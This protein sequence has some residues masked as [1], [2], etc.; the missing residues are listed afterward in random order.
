MGF[1]DRFRSNPTPAPD[2]NLSRS[3]GTYLR[4]ITEEE[5]DIL[6]HWYDIGRELY[7]F[8]DGATLGEMDAKFCAA[9]DAY[10]A[11]PKE[12]REDPTPWILGAAGIAGAAVASLSKEDLSWY[13]LSDEYG[14]D[15]VV[16]L[17][18]DS[19]QITACPRTAMEKR[20]MPDHP[21]GPA[22]WVQNSVEKLTS[23]ITSALNTWSNHDSQT[24][25]EILD[26][27]GTLDGTVER[28]IV[29][30]PT[31][32]LR[33]AAMGALTLGEP[34]YT[35]LI[36]SEPIYDSDGTPVFAM[37]LTPTNVTPHVEDSIV[38]NRNHIRQMIAPFEGQYGY[39]TL[40]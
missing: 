8:E 13:F 18:T 26:E 37:F 20:W 14:E 2:D 38:R 23:D 19:H 15:L 1:F 32:E 24:L 33:S 30:F 25:H 7:A 21:S 40:N 12:E 3:A 35:F 31:S 29:V 39:W 6:S 27:R 16:G 4:H 17:V 28:H 11:T 5:A 10:W 34:E 22:L 36:P 9:R